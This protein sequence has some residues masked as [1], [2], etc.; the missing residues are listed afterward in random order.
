MQCVVNCNDPPARARAVLID[1]HHQ[2]RGNIV[3]LVPTG[4]AW[5]V[6]RNDPQRSR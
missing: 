5:V 4:R 2:Q 6:C 1:I 3:G